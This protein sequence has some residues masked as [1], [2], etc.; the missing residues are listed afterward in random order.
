LHESQEN[1]SHGRRSRLEI[2]EDA[3]LS[4][5]AD[6][7]DFLWL[8]LCES[9]DLFIT[10]LNEITKGDWIKLLS[11]LGQERHEFVGRFGTEQLEENDTK[12]IDLT[13]DEITS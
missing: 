10:R 9:Q 8:P 7:G 3:I 6:L 1:N 12:G 2:R 11:F 4:D 13:L 5:L